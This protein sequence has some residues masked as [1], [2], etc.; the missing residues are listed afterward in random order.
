[1]ST[2]VEKRYSIPKSRTS[3]TITM[4]SAPVAPDIIPGLPQNTAVIIPTINAACNPII[5]LISATNENAIASGTSANATVKPDNISVLSC[6]GSQSSRL[7][8]MIPKKCKMESNM[9]LV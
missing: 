9:M 5:G 2:S 7:K 1:M 3:D 4:A 6:F 8:S